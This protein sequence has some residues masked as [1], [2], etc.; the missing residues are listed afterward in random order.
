MIFNL[1]VRS[2]IHNKRELFQNAGSILY[3]DADY[4]TM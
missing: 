4:Y 1:P 2:Y 3:S